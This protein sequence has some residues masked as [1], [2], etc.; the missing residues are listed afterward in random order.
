[1]HELRAI[2]DVQLHA[3]VDR[4]R[5]HELDFEHRIASRLAA[6]RDP[7]NPHA[8]AP[9]RRMSYT[10]DRLRAQRAKA[11]RELLRRNGPTRFA[12]A[13]SLRMPHDKQSGLDRARP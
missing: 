13:N 5:S 2:N 10:L 8:D 6:V 4:L 3:W 1:M 11:Q 9:Y 12:Q 7:S